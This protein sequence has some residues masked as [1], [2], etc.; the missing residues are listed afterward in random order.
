MF[1]PIKK[2]HLALSNDE[3]KTTLLKGEFG[4]LGTVGENGYPY[5]IP[6]N[7]VY[8]NNSIYF[9]GSTECHKLENIAF[10]DKVS[11]TVV[12]YTKVLPAKFDTEYESI[13]AFGTA[14]EIGESEKEPILLEILNKYSPDYLSS[15]KACI[16]KA[17]NALKI[18][19]IDIAHISGKAY[20]EN[21]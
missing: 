17:I 21:K 18:I 6:V 5:T 20:K 4:V 11:F 1:K 14:T 13:I 2:N 19:K 10:N 9:H 16:D 3:I 12:T 7:Y 15:G 8:L